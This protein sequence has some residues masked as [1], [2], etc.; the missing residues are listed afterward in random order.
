MAVS[1]TLAIIGSGI[2]GLG[3]AY[4]LMDKYELK[5]FEKENYAGGHSHTVD[6]QEDGQVL[7]VDTGFIV[8][9]KVTYPLLL[10]LFET[11]KVPYHKSDMSFSFYN[12]DNNLQYHGSSLSGLFAQRKNLLRPSYYAF[13]LEINRF[14]KNAPKHLPELKPNISL[15]EYLE[16]EKYSPDFI[17]H[18]LIPMSSA[19]WSTP[20][21]LML[22]FPAAT[23]IRFF[24]NHGFLGLNTQYQ[25]Y[26]VTGGSKTYVNLLR[27]EI[28]KRQGRDVFLNTPVTKVETDGKKVKVFTHKKKEVFD[29]VVLACHAPEAL[30]LLAKPSP[31]QKKVLSAFRYQPNLAILHTDETVMPPLKRIWCSWNYKRKATVTSTVYWMNRLQKLPTEIN[32]FVSINEYRKISPQKIIKKIEY[33][34]PLFDTKAIVEQ[35]NLPK[36]NEKGPVYFCGAYFRYGFH[37]DGLWSAKV[38]SERLL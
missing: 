22:G 36:L 14:N 28:Q 4:Y 16:K 35:S 25:W 2:S 8:F 15:K 34:H 5:I 24:Y 29:K 12:E 9:N 27:K 31:L 21:D 26:T 37:E 19:V 33:E 3:L 20:P 10:E 23:L 30:S 18:F 38:L 17:N 13:L 1:K 32:Y 7:P 6:V 11:L